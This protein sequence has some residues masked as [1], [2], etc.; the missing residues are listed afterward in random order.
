MWGCVRVS[1]LA[2]VAA[3]ALMSLAPGARADSCETF[4]GS[5][6]YTDQNCDKPYGGAPKKVAPPAAA[7]KPDSSLRD[8]LKRRLQDSGSAGEANNTKSVDA[9][10][11]RVV[12][13][14]TRIDAALNDSGAPNAKQRYDKAMGDLR[15]AYDDAGKA[16]PDRANLFK[17][18]KEGDVAA[19]SARAADAAWNAPKTADKEAGP[20]GPA[21]V[22]SGNGFVY[23][24]DA[25]I[26]G[27]NNV[28]C[29]EIS[30]DGKQCTAV[31]LADGDMGWRDSIATPCRAADLAQR[32]AFLAANPD[33]AAVAA[34][35]PSA[36]RLDNP[37]CKT[38]V[39]NYVAAARANDGP[40]A[41]AGLIALKQ[42]GGCGVLKDAAAAEADPRFIARGDT[43]MLD[44]T[45][46]ACDRQPEACA[47]I[48]AQL[49]AGTSSGAIAAM[50]SNAIGIGL[51]IGL[52]M[53]QGVLAAQQASMPVPRHV[54]SNMNSLAARPVRSTYG[55]GSPTRAAPPPRAPVSK[56]AIGGD[57]WCTAQ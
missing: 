21:N 28:S 20:T 52:A 36:F 7:K 3:T 48:A 43:P 34:G 35:T 41:S 24:C 47:Q 49:K 33:V 9:L 18:L 55:Q 56:C 54:E 40:N 27:G 57:G 8:E 4:P 16:F 45:A 5:Q 26:A 15:K 23:V 39:Q 37:N 51:E 44:Q 12:D 38:I 2:G 50:Y 1:I 13:A 10:N 32:K 19:A 14:R 25:A 30:P 6:V 42:A 46:L 22:G 11:Q 53:G 17:N 29:R 31:T